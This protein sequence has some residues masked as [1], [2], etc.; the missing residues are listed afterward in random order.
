M[1]TLGLDA[2]CDI[3]LN[4]VSIADFGWLRHIHTTGYTSDILPVGPDTIQQLHEGHGEIKKK[5]EK[6]ISRIL[7]R[8]D[9][10]A[11]QQTA[12]ETQTGKYRTMQQSETEFMSAKLRKTVAITVLYFSTVYGF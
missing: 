6:Q 5:E 9:K 2:F 11:Q 12:R 1:Q 7:V 3:V 10:P 8:E 4:T